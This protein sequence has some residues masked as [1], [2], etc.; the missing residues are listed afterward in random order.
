MVIPTQQLMNVGS[1]HLS[2]IP[3]WLHALMD[4]YMIQVLITL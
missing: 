4:L 1:L 2:L 3:G